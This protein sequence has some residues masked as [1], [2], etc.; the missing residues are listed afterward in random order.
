MKCNKCSHE[1]DRP[2]ELYNGRWCCPDCKK[3]IFPDTDTEFAVTAHNRE[4]FVRSEEYYYKWLTSSDESRKT[5]FKYLDK[6]VNLCYE[7][8]FEYHPSALMRLGYYYDKGYADFGSAGAERWRAAYFY[9]KAVLFNE[10][11]GVNTQDGEER[12]VDEVTQIKLQCG[13]YMLELLEC[14]P[15]EVRKKTS[16]DGFESIEKL[17]V[18]VAQKIVDLGGAVESYGGGSS[19][20]EPD[21]AAMAYA[22]LRACAD[23]ERAPVFAIFKLSKSQAQRLIFESG[24]ESFSIVESVG[25]DLKLKI[26]QAYDEKEID[27]KF[28]DFKSSNALMNYVK[29]KCSDKG[30]YLCFFNW[31]GGH[32]YLK[33]KKDRNVVCSALEDNSCAAIKM[34]IKAGKYNSCVFYDDDFYKYDEGRK[35]LNKKEMEKFVK[36]VCEEE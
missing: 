25:R 21:V 5:R 20:R 34:L 19:S 33:R 23:E 11:R 14:P 6:A 7:S 28:A 22:A 12:Y 17:R 2:L 30:I 26:A 9:Y 18:A 10:H 27:G 16:F 3:D 8:A 32:K 35:G 1:I 31:L 15:V 29:D 36:E 4:S 13:K 24:N